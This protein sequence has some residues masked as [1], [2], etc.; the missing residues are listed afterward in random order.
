MKRVLLVLA[1]A[2]VAG[3][4]ALGQ[5]VLQPE[6]QGSGEFLQTG[7]VYRVSF[8]N[9]NGIGVTANSNFYIRPTE[10]LNRGWVEGD[11]SSSFDKTN[12]FHNGATQ[13]RFNTALMCTVEVVTP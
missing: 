12:G 8:C 7:V 13:A 9:G 5:A 4:G 10:Q 1:F 3:A 6:R 11:Y 2:V